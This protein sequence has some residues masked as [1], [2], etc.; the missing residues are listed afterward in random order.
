MPDLNDPKPVIGPRGV[1][2]EKI[3]FI[4]P[5]HN[6]EKTL[7]QT[8]SSVRQ[9]DIDYE[10]L[11]VENGST[12]HTEKIV[13]KLSERY[14]NIR[15]FT[16]EKGVSR[17]RN[18]GIEEA[19]GKWIF[20]L[21]ADD[22]CLKEIEKLVTQNAS[23]DDADLI[24]GSYMKDQTPIIHDYSILNTVIECDDRLKLWM[25]SRPTLRMQAWAKIYR[26]DYLKK[27]NLFFNEELSYSEDS[28]FVIR[29]LQK[30][31]KVFVSD[32]PIYQYKTGTPSVM[33]SFIDGR[34]G[35]YIKAL[36][37]AEK[38]VENESPEVKRAFA[39]YVS[40]HVNIIG[41]HDIFSCDI[42]ES[43]IR[44]C[45]KM[46]QCLKEGVIQRAIE[47]ITI[48]SGIQNLPVVLCKHRL[49][50]MAGLIYYLRS[51]QNKRRYSRSF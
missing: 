29:A 7:E 40:A 14:E 15:A 33:R 5:A 22:V 44:R 31:E 11:L 16:S 36:E 32:I 42:R 51:L 49:T 28:E 45:Q 27:N 47:E 18:K 24:I 19:T 13:S 9:L 30:T 21:D 41:V 23:L 20:F 39:D 38:D 1:I 4:I 10:I 6:A 35:A 12:D 8:V 3:S 43:W 25:L 46:G 48:S 34:I 17:A 26:N 37:V 2:V 50:A